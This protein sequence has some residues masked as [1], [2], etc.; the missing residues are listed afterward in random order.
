[1]VRERGGDGGELQ[2]AYSQHEIDRASSS[3]QSM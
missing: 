1:V 2:V 3:L